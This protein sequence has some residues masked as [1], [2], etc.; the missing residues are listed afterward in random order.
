MLPAA[1]N[2]A[3]MKLPTAALS[4]CLAAGLM[5]LS[6][7]T[8][9][10]QKPFLLDTKVDP[11]PNSS[12]FNV[13]HAAFTVAKNW[14]LPRH[15]NNS[16][17]V[18]DK[19]SLALA[20]G[21]Q[22]LFIFAAE[23]HPWRLPVPSLWRDL[24]QKIRAAGFNTVSIYTHWGLIQPRSDSASID[25]SGVNDLDFFLSVAKE[26]GLFVIVRPGPYINAE[27]TMG[28]M[29]PWTANID[30]TL[31]TNDT[32]WQDAW[33]PY[34]QAISDVVVKHQLVF[35]PAKPNHLHGG[36]VILVQADNE[37][38]TGVAQRAYM[39]EVVSFFKKSGVTI[40]IT[41]NDPG[42]D[43]NFV[44]IVDLYGFDSYP[45]RFDCS[46]PE[47]WVPMR[48]DYL[49]YH[50]E[51]NP[52][53][54]LYI[55]EF[56][57]GSYDPFDG[58]GYGECAKMTNASFAK[59]ANQALV[60]QKV[61]LLSLYM[62][63]GGTNWGG[64]A[65]PDVYSSY[66][67]GA[68][69]NEHRQTT[70]KFAEL[71]RQGHFFKAFPDLA[72]TEQIIDRSGF[73]ISQVENLD[74]NKDKVGAEVF[75]TTVLE[76]PETKSKFY[77]VRYD[78]TTESRR[79]R[80]A[81]EVESMGES[82]VLGQRRDPAFEKLIGTNHLHGR[83]SHM[84]PV[85]QQLP[86]GL[87]LRFSTSNVYRVTTIANIVVISLDFGPGQSFEYG[88]QIQGHSNNFESMQMF[89]IGTN[90][91]MRKANREE[92]E[93]IEAMHS[94]LR[95]SAKEVRCAVPAFADGEK[96]ARFMVYGTQEGTYIVLTF[97][98]TSATARDFAAPA[99]YQKSEATTLARTKDFVNR[100]FGQSQDSVVML[101]V[102]L[103]RNATYSST[104]APLDTVELWGSVSNDTEAVL[105]ALPGLKHIYWNGEK[106][107]A[108]AQD[109]AEWFYKVSLPGPNDGKAWTPPK[110]SELKWRWADSIPEASANFDDSEW[111][112]A[113]KN[114]SFNPYTKDSSLDTQGDIL[115]ASEY[116]FHGN[117]LLWRGHF[118]TPSTPVKDV[119]IKVEGGRSFAFSAYLNGVFLGS[120]EANRVKSAVG[121]TFLIPEGTLTENEGGRM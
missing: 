64:L 44:D 9:A 42:R 109:G 71:K 8:F 49:K 93:Q 89:N 10:D 62:V 7:E 83:D 115:F 50:M 67:Y 51:T 82:I 39:K 15:S 48:D 28:G 40:P 14:T 120:A 87:L 72:M 41:Y 21:R 104:N 75:R 60:A 68:A 45:Q 1:T 38:E 27:T 90:S 99:K 108:L 52:D 116:G 29:A 6:G 103:L 105:M 84:I 18:F 11:A 26:E 112:K 59:V 30:A 78:N 5:L 25:L 65:Q 73:N 102:D 91:T 19:Y 70:E 86:G 85:D 110:P 61:T 80:F 56:Q 66:D 34:I 106:V 58:P 17:V 24:L 121:Q 57:G 88:L 119:Y 114:S 96:D 101:K 94:D 54:P 97:S 37:Y 74:D 98:P 12:R 16:A 46:H 63:Y 92:W 23:F 47:K 55:P 69:L 79:I 107:K 20:G 33:K 35:D 95:R 3:K 77:I 81:L 13:N 76:N 22:R 117:N 100:F 4:S 111:V 2:I 32:A 53:Q 31:R 36:S 43:N 113:D 118:R